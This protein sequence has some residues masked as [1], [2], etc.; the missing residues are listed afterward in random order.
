MINVLFSSWVGATKHGDASFGWKAVEDMYAQECAQ[1]SSG[2]A[3]MVPKLKHAH[4]LRD[5]WTKLNV[6]PAKIMQVIKTFCVQKLS[7]M[8][9]HTQ[10]YVHTHT[11]N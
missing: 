11:H 9:M 8:S 10:T 7:S 6:V 2:A 4:I 1:Q 3:R 5:S